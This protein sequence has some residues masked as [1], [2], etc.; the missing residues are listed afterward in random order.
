MVTLRV[1]TLLPEP[2][3]KPPAALSDESVM[4]L[5]VS[6]LQ[7]DDG[8]AEVLARKKIRE[9]LPDVLDSFEAMLR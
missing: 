7:R 4:P 2:L 9:G 5:P 8:P 6:R 3:E 1:G